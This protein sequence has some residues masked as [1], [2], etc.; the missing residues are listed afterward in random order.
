NCRKLQPSIFDDGSLNLEARWKTGKV[1]QKIK[2]TLRCD[3]SPGDR[4]AQPASA[5]IASAICPVSCERKQTEATHE[6]A[7]PG[8]IITG[9]P[10]WF[11]E[12]L[13]KCTSWVNYGFNL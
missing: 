5:S 13:V 12:M 1:S 10:P 2:G 11:T 7:H 3:P 6:R 4:K 9:R 8:R